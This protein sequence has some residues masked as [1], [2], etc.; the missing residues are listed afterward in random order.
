MRPD[1][2]GCSRRPKAIVAM[3]TSASIEIR[4]RC[5]QRPTAHQAILL[6]R[7]GLH[8]PERLEMIEWC[9]LPLPGPFIR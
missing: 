4:K 7:L 8:L 9:F 1:G 6:Q 3:P 5:V 2:W